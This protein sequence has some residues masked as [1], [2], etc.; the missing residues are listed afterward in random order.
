MQVNLNSNMNQ[1]QPNF[2][3][4][5]MNK[6]VW[7]PEIVKAL[8]NSTLIKKIDKKYP[9]AAIAYVKIFDSD[10]FMGDDC[11][12]ALMQLKLNATKFFQWTLSS[13]NSDVPEECF[14]DFLNNTT[15]EEIESKAVN[16]LKPLNRLEIF[17]HNIEDT[18]PD[19]Q[20][21]ANIV[22]TSKSSE[23]KQLQ[24]PKPSLLEKVL[25]ILCLKK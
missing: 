3:I 23:T 19:E 17:P 14:I 15:L 16:N 7:S 11:Y 8:E 5:Y 10:P 22:S 9:E 12:T 2:G 4:R 24:A 20:C 13:H 18:V 1:I 21:M 6:Q 25:R